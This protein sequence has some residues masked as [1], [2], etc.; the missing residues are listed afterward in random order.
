LAAGID[1]NSI[2]SAADY[3]RVMS[4]LRGNQAIYNANNKTNFASYARESG[5]GNVN[6]DNVTA[7]TSYAD[8]LTSLGVGSEDYIW[9]MNDSEVKSRFDTY[10]EGLIAAQTAQE[11]LSESA[12]EMGVN[13][14]KAT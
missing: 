10:Q 13:I 3:K 6:F 14:E 4:E 11:G 12:I 9:A 1:P 5:H 8:W 2:T 7:T